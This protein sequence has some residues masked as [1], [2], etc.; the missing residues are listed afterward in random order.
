MR[1]VLA[2]SRLIGTAFAVGLAVLLGLPPF[3]L[4]ASELA[5]ARGTAQAHL[6]WALGVALLL[7]VIAFAALAR[8]AS[9]MLLGAP[10]ADTGEIAV[11]ATV[12]GALLAGIAACALLGVTAGPLTELLHHA[13]LVLGATQ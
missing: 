11:P 8:N 3:A 6:T 4:F 1:G 10:P 9:R 12:T 7:I 5:I 2:R 13:A